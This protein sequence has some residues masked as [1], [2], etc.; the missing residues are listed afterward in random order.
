MHRVIDHSVAV[1]FEASSL[2]EATGGETDP[3]AEQLLLA[4]R[5]EPPHVRV[6]ADGDTAWSVVLSFP[7]SVQLDYGLNQV[8]RALVQIQG[9]VEGSNDSDAAV[10]RYLIKYLLTYGASTRIKCRL[11]VK[12]ETTDYGILPDNEDSAPFISETVL[13]FD[14]WLVAVAN[15]AGPNV[16]LT[17]SHVSA[18]LAESSSV[19]N[20]IAAGY[21]GG[22]TYNSALNP[23]IR[24][25]NPLVNASSTAATLNGIFS[26]SASTPD[27]T[28]TDFWGYS[29]PDATGGRFDKAGIR[30]FFAKIASDDLF[31]YHTLTD[32]N[33][34]QICDVSAIKNDSAA[35]AL[36]R[37]EPFYEPARGDADPAEA[38]A[39]W[40]LM[41][42]AV[43]SVRNTDRA[44]RAGMVEEAGEDFYKVGYRFGVPLAFRVPTEKVLG[45][46]P[47]RVLANSVG[48]LVLGNVGPSSM[49]DK[50]VSSFCPSLQAAVVPMA[51]RLL[52]VPVHP[53]R[54]KDWVT[55]SVNEVDEFR[56]EL[57]DTTPVRG[58]YLLG[59]KVNFTGLTPGSE[60]LP[61]VPHAV[62]DG[63]GAGR[64]AFFSCPDWLNG[65]EASSHVAGGAVLGGVRRAAG[66]PATKKKAADAVKP[67][68]AWEPNDP[69]FDGN[70]DEGGPVLTQE[71]QDRQT[72]V[73]RKDLRLTIGKSLAK[74]L[75]AREH[76][77]KR[78]ASLRTRPRFDIGPG[79]AIRVEVPADRAEGTDTVRYAT[80]IT[81]TVV[82]VTMVLSS[83]ANTA[84]C[85]YEL[86]DVR[87]SADRSQDA[88]TTPDSPHGAVA[89]D[90]Y[91]PFWSIEW[92]GCPLADSQ[93]VRDS[94][95]GND[96][97]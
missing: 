88:A 15:D 25:P 17:L 38:S 82:R 12:Q 45:V 32:E 48:S 87:T 54:N 16:T 37:F 43:K 10:D 14:G 64:F 33:G 35:A 50:L 69:L 74:T 3:N 61:E 97:L 60:N 86:S 22:L 78:N 91:H 84:Y 80:W 85:A 59:R 20:A 92:Y 26:A 57:D 18:S 19:S 72:A 23:L 55:V 39:R 1:G 41:T 53:C 44:N 51:D 11:Y 46:D 94:L 47:G 63:C 77:K 56:L 96:T 83:E 40:S 24:I 8:P 5:S 79:S 36:D 89:S 70:D 21:A 13:A 6:T 90:A 62:Y 2:L 81:G 30:R 75:A 34:Q 49:W 4:V 68:R 71:E 95:G 76:L 52:F 73:A 27:T 29:V 67:V 65:Y 93:W 66:D 31:S 28:E 9:G 7:T 58:A 42:S